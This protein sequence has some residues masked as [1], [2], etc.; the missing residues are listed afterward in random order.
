MPRS[1]SHAACGSI[2]WPQ[3]RISRVTSS[4]NDADPA[5]APA[6]TSLCPFRY[7]VALVMTTSAPCS[8]GR[9]LIGLAKVASTRRASPNSLVTCAI[10]PRSSTRSVGLVGVSTK[11]ARVVLRTDFRQSRG[12]VGST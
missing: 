6:I 1:T 9:R 10:G 8:I 7:L 5:T 11:I 2:D 3:S 4:M 12:W